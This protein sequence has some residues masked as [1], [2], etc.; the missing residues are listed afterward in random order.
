MSIKHSVIHCS[1]TLRNGGKDFGMQKLQFNYEQ[2][3]EQFL[4]NESC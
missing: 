1:K 3:P 4:I 2:V